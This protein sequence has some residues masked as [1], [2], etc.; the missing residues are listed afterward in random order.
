MG[1]ILFI[2]LFI[3][4]FYYQKE[5]KRI[6][7]EI[8]I[9]QKLYNM[10]CLKIA[11]LAP[12]SFECK[13]HKPE[14]KEELNTLYIELTLTFVVTLF[15]AL[16]MSFYLAKMAVKPMRDAYEMMD[17]FIDAMIHDLN[18]PITTAKLNTESLLNMKIDEASEKRLL[19]IERSLTQLHNLQLQLTNSIKNVSMDYKDVKFSLDTLLESIQETSSLIRLQCNNPLDI[20][21]DKLMIERI[22]NNLISNAIKYNKNSNQ[23]EIT[24]DKTILSIKDKGKGI[25]D[26]NKVFDKYYR[27]NSSLSGLGIGLGVVKMINEHYNLNMKIESTVNKGTQI[28]LDFKEILA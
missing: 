12:K 7:K 25:K 15:F 11:S 1:A 16:F 27:E 4:F 2:Y 5:T 20:Y 9:S 24:L 21:A 18:T 26:I 10:Q 17:E 22:L 19:R 23:I 3:A 6:S 28:Q 8:V 13:L 14:I